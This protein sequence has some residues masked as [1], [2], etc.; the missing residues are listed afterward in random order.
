VR[1]CVMMVMHVVI[2]GEGGRHEGTRDKIRRSLSVCHF[3]LLTCV[4]Y[5]PVPVSIRIISSSTSLAGLDT[6][7]CYRADVVGLCTP[8]IC[9]LLLTR[10]SET[11]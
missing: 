1:N 10:P 6:Q 8:P 11:V 9:S 2:G 7:A 5:D 4:I 3:V